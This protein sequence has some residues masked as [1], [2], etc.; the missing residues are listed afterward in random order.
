VADQPAGHRPAGRYRYDRRSSTW[1]WSAE[2]F[3]LQGVVPGQPP[4]TDSLLERQHPDDRPRVLAALTAA[5]ATARPFTVRSRVLPPDGGQREVILVGEPAMGEDGTVIAVEGMCV[6]LT[7]CSAPDP[8]GGQVAALQTEIE[9][10][11][12]AMASR[13]VIE[14]AKGIL[15]LLTTCSDRVAFDLLTHM[16]SHTHRKV[17]EVATEIVASAAEAARLPDDLRAI[18]R[19]ACPPAHALR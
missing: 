16:S 18:L 7:H 17:R 6:D 14:Q 12:A 3:A 2:M 5:C 8:A 4:C 19:D 15:M 10:L 1:W 11:R 9:Q 13:A